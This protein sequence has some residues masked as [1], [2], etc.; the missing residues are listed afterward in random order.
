MAS[1]SMILPRNDYDYENASKLPSLREIFFSTD[2]QIPEYI[3]FV[4]S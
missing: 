1:S 3:G 2:I 4:S